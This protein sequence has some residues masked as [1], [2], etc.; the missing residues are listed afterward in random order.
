MSFRFLLSPRI[1]S[2]WAV[3]LLICAPGCFTPTQSAPH[4]TGSDGAS[5]HVASPPNG[6][7]PPPAGPN[8]LDDDKWVRGIAMPGKTDSDAPAFRWRNPSL[9]QMSAQPTERQ[10]RLESD[11]NEGGVRG[12]NA[13]ILLARSHQPQAAPALVKAVQDPTLK[14]PLRLA[15]AEA[16]A[17]LPE[18]IAVRNL[19]I[20]LKGIERKIGATQP[21]YNADLYAELLSALAQH[22]TAD[23][24]PAFTRALEKEE[25]PARLAALERWSKLGKTP[26]PPKAIE[27]CQDSDPRVRLAALKG[28][29]AR[30]NDQTEEQLQRSTHDPV[31]DVQFAAIEGLGK[32]GTEGAHQ[33]LDRLVMGGGELI[34][35]AA[36]SALVQLGDGN[37]V[38]TAAK[39]KS[40]RVRVAAANNLSRST[41]DTQAATAR[42]LLTD[43]SGEVRRAVIDAVAMWPL[44][45]AGPI[46]LTALETSGNLGRKAAA[47]QLAERW[48]PAKEYS[49]DAPDE[50]RAARLAELRTKWRQEFGEANHDPASGGDEP[51]P[52]EIKA[53]SN[54]IP[55]STAPSAAME[56]LRST[57]LEERRRGAKDLAQLA[58]RQPLSPK[59]F[60][61]IAPLVVAEQDA[62]VWQSMFV[63]LA[64]DERPA[65]AEL[66]C[67]ALSHPSADVRRRACEHLAAHGRPEHA[68][69]LVASLSDTQIPVQIA[70]AKALGRIGSEHDYPALTRLLLAGDKTV[71]VTAAESLLELGAPAGVAALERLTYDNE[72]KVRRQAVEAM[73]QSDCREFVP[74]LIRLLDDRPSVK[75]AAVAAL[76]HIVG[77]EAIRTPEGPAAFDVTDDVAR[78]WKRWYAESH[79]AK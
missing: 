47:R 37:I 65:A 61:E 54:E 69:A 35:A 36:V 27:L 64:S 26:V 79:T 16:L 59:L 44:R 70:A 1:G 58:A 77:P 46:L 20:A 39:D 34:R 2:V 56:R 72:E 10:P 68:A 60:A 22:C 24:E 49:A 8:L 78:R 9:E 28:L 55:S 62:T 51:R 5:E 74:T 42:L 25:L 53:V 7:A 71:R 76:E 52:R 13:A 6:S 11:L 45:S 29:I 73:G 38:A 3:L 75:L 12:A 18:E 15:A 4:P 21:A 33:T 57:E 50:R 41:P 67:A 23:D 40:W 63:I 32:L 66:E 43:A 19:H 14:Q 17:A 31:L 30:P 48:P